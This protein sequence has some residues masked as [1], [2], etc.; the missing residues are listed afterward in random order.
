MSI[1]MLYNEYIP[2]S[3][4]DSIIHKNIIKKLKNI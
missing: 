3:F 2:K 1:S 4:D